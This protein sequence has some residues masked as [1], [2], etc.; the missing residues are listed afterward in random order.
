[1][2]KKS[3]H[4]SN[5]VKGPLQCYKLSECLR[6]VSP[7]VEART[8]FRYLAGKLAIQ[9]ERVVCL[10][11]TFKGVLYIQIKNSSRQ[12]AGALLYT[13]NSGNS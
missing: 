9:I 11:S 1:M 8:L 3:S 13:A 7:R 10:P 12:N 5:A 4:S 6:H 2:N